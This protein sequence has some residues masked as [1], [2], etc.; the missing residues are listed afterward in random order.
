MILP[1]SPWLYT[2][3]QLNDF[4][5]AEIDKHQAELAELYKSDMTMFEKK[6][7]GIVIGTWQKKGAYGRETRERMDRII[8]GDI[9]FAKIQFSILCGE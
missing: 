3:Y 7:R 6:V 9:D 8:N 2:E 4:V 1:T 5:H